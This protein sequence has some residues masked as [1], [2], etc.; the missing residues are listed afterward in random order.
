MNVLKKSFLAVL[1]L[2]V[3]ISLAP[4]G[5]AGNEPV[6]AAPGTQPNKPVRAID[7][8]EMAGFK[9]ITMFAFKYRQ[10]LQNMAAILEQAR[11]TAAISDE[12][13]KKL[14]AELDR[15]NEVEP[16]LARAGWNQTAIEAFDRQIANYES[17]FDKA[18]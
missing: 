5:N 16:S 3:I 11:R 13:H 1:A 14:Q 10:K 8:P 12:N 4:A 15:F 2:L 6:Q 17:E 9:R 18:N 7:R